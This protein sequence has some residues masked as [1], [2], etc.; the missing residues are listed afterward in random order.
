MTPMTCSRVT[1]GFTVRMTI[2]PVVTGEMACAW[3]SD[4]LAIEVAPF[5]VRMSARATFRIALI[6]IGG[7]PDLHLRCKSALRGRLFA[8]MSMTHEAKLH[9][10]TRRAR[11]R[12]DVSERCPAPQFPQSGRGARGHPVS[13]E[14]GGSCARGA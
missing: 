12:R 7:A 4:G 9:S 3:A 1:P 2:T 5:K 11:W 10:Q 6:G 13:G 8:I 14:S